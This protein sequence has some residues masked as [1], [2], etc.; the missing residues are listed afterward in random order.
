MKLTLKL[1]LVKLVRHR[2]DSLLYASKVEVYF[3]KLCNMSDL[4]DLEENLDL[5]CP[6]RV[7]RKFPRNRMLS[8]YFHNKSGKFVKT[9]FLKS[10][11]LTYLIL[12]SKSRDLI[13]C[14][15]FNLI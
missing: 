1:L 11:F 4:E 13:L 2:A 5:V 12:Q 8:A 14:I 3:L 15:G 9:Y 6:N 10:E 7:N